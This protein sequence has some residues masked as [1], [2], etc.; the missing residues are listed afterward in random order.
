MK[1]SLHY[2]FVYLTNIPRVRFGCAILAKI[3]SYPTSASGIIV[4]LKTPT[5]YGEF[6]PTLFVKTTDLRLVFNF[7]QTSIVTIFGEH[8]QSEL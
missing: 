7:E 4:L 2:M 6:F 5:K 3:I 8:G 1:Q